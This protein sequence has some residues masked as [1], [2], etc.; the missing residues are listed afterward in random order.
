MSESLV[1]C[2]FFTFSLHLT[3]RAQARQGEPL[4]RRWDGPESV[5]FALIRSA[6]RPSRC[7]PSASLRLF[8][9]SAE[10]E[11]SDRGHVGLGGVV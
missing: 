9:S 3:L 1:Q 10:S 11:V 2:D 7:L 6:W 5:R 4:H 8:A